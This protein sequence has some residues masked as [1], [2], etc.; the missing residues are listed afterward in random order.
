MTEVMTVVRSGSARVVD[1]VDGTVIA[2]YAPG[3]D[4]TVQGA[5][6]AARAAF[7]AWAAVTPRERAIRLLALADA[8]ENS[9]PPVVAADAR[10]R[11][12]DT[13]TARAQFVEAADV[14]RFYAGAA[15]AS[16][17][18][19]ALRWVEHHHSRVSTR[20]LGVVG[21]I[22]PWN[23]P[24]LIAAW[25]LAPALA[26]GCTCVVKPAEQT[27]AFATHLA[28]LA[29]YH[30][31]RDVVAVVLGDDETGALL[32]GAGCDAYAFTG[33][34]AAGVAVAR[35]AA[36]APVSLELGGNCPAIFT[37]T[38]PPGSE[39]D[40]VGAAF[41][42]AGQSCAAPS[43][44]I[45]L[46]EDG[47]ARV[48]A[49]VR[50]YRGMQPLI[51]QEARDRALREVKRSRG[52]H[53]YTVQDVRPPA[54]GWHMRAA[55]AVVR[56]GAQMPLRQGET[57]APVITVERADDFAHALA[58]ALDPSCGNDLAASC[59]T[60]DLHEA[61]AAGYVL[62]LHVGEVWINC[63]LVQTAELPHSGRGGVDMGAA[64]L[65]QYRRPT[66]V[67]TRLP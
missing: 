57:F 28:A 4:E 62:G 31:G 17:G 42:N 10:E 34:R 60:T 12:I 44:V 53:T 51:S 18:P 32:A 58:L 43:R 49:A 45:T 54:Q 2:Q 56:A 5:V 47:T 41:F 22:L 38:A 52:L 65:D 40:L 11:G 50:A 33:S 25:R 27:P 37:D 55:A 13:G 3:R 46:S 67:T 24:A 63:H 23:Y 20:P 61:H 1:P 26:A 35:A 59:W 6:G 15:R 29:R 21:V 8:I 14:F 64:A 48:L 7:A 36:P 16:L 39:H 9:P 66:T 30:L 19:T